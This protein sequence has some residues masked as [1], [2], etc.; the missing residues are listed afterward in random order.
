MGFIEPGRRLK[1]RKHNKTTKFRH[2]AIADLG[3]MIA[4]SNPPSSSP[5][6]LQD[7]PLEVLYRIFILAKPQNNLPLVNRYFNH[8]LKFDPYRPK[9]DSFSI[10]NWPNI[11][12]VISMIKHWY[13]VDLNTRLDF[14]LILD[15]YNYYNRLLQRFVDQNTPNHGQLLESLSILK[16]SIERF[17]QNTYAIN[18]QMLSNNFKSGTLVDLL[19]NPKF[20][21]HYMG[22]HGDYVISSGS[23]ILLEIRYRHRY[24]ALKFKELAYYVNKLTT[25]DN[26]EQ[27]ETT[28]AESDLE[29]VKETFNKENRKL[30]RYNDHNSMLDSLSPDK[31][32]FYSFKDNKLHYNFYL[33]TSPQDFPL[34]IYK[35]GVYSMERLKLITSLFTFNYQFFN[36]DELLSN[37]FMKFT[38]KNL[39]KLHYNQVSLSTFI[40]KIL[41]LN[42]MEKYP[43]TSISIIQV[44]MLYNSYETL[45]C[46]QF[47]SNIDNQSI[48]YDISFALLLLLTLFYSKQDQNDRD[49][50]KCV[51]QLKNNTLA[52]ALMK[53]SDRPD[54]DLLLH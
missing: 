50:W 49:I 16:S 37:T 25:T 3:S 43:L 52:K 44:F 53:F 38:P 5:K 10:S 46:T 48:S 14:S 13:I 35:H 45:D 47:D 2:A 19:N 21:R 28:L 11:S 24:I 9:F 51:L 6:C 40:D 34:V 4:S 23:M 20:V 30:P 18:E 32:E 29:K 39:P 54:Y 31:I 12:L 15:K 33:Q 1:R 8:I 22:Y 42:D 36:I 27:S 26:D 41:E 7:L 17:K